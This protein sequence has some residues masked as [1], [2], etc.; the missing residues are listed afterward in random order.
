MIVWPITITTAILYK[1]YCN[2]SCYFSFLFFASSPSSNDKNISQE[3]C[4]N[5]TEQYVHIFFKLP[6]Y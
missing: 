1:N 3:C 5:T 4:Q 2:Y 6:G